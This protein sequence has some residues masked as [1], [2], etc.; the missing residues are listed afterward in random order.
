MFAV[1]LLQRVAL[2]FLSCV[3]IYT[4]SVSRKYSF[5]FFFGGG[6]SHF[7][8]FTAV[9]LEFSSI[10]VRGF[11][12]P[13]NTSWYRMRLAVDN[14]ILTLVVLDFVGLFVKAADHEVL[15]Q[16]R[17]AGSWLLVD[18]QTAL[19][20]IHLETLSRKDTVTLK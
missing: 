1:S 13:E 20:A 12:C 11:F 18:H 17:P 6:G 16:C 14:L 15:S 10:H 3:S 8:Y 19:F 7:S 9:P 2:S 5:F 4:C